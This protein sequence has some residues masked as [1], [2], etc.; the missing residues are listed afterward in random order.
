[1]T[2]TENDL[3]LIKKFE[4]ILKHGF[5]ASGS[6][7]TAVYNKVFGTKLSSTNCSSCIRSRVQKLVQ[8]KN[9]YLSQLE[10][11]KEEEQV[12]EKEK[13]KQVEEKKEEKANESHKRGNGGKKGKG[14]SKKNDVNG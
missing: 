1:M 12:I 7:V 10:L 6:E 8:A 11:P 9:L 4:D 14:R 3:I 2:I 13:N 5:Y